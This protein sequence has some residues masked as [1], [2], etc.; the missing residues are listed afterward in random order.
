MKLFQFLTENELREVSVTIY[1]HEYK[2]ITD[3][4]DEDIN[5]EIYGG[6]MDYLFESDNQDNRNLILMMLQARFHKAQAITPY[7]TI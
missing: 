2:I 7:A 4:T 3:K 5:Y 6:I 1:G